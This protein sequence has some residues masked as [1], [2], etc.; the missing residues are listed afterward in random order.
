MSEELS[1]LQKVYFYVF[2]FFFN[3][4]VFIKFVYLCETITGHRI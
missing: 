3:F 4:E 2:F 1:G